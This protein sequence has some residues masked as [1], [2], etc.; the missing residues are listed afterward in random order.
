M[1]TSTWAGDVVVGVDGSE[2]SDRALD[3]AAAE[4]HHRGSALHIVHGVGTAPDPD[5][6]TGLTN[7]DLVTVQ[8][9]RSMLDEA[10]ERATHEHPGL[11][12]T[13][14]LAYEEGPQAVLATAAGAALIVLGTRGRGGFAALLL[15]S[16]TLRVAA[17][18]TCPLVVVRGERAQPTIGT[19]MVGVQDEKD[20]QTVRFAL[21]TAARWHASVRALHAWQPL[22]EVGL[23]ATQ[24]DTVHELRAAHTALLSRTVE[25]AHLTAPEAPLSQEVVVSRAATALVEA[26]SEADLLVVAAH[27]PHGPLG[28]RLG[29]VV[30]AVLH[31]SHCPV[32]MVPDR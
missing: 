30:H 6:G 9:A 29:P 32:A 8:S 24:V 3:W 10:G 7:G 13:T 5:K 31:H 11:K 15:G 25:A 22:G 16:V 19:V 14:T 18:T 20:A 21:I 23:M 4:A 1:T 26:S 27:R 2:D 17:H 12:V 28:L